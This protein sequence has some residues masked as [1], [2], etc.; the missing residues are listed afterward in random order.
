LDIKKIRELWKDWMDGKINA[1]V[2]V[3]LI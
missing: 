1:A 3:I 2:K